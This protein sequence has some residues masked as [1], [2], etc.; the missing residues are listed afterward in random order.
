MTGKWSFAALF[1]YPVWN[2]EIDKTFYNCV[3]IQV[4]DIREDGIIIC[5]FIA[6]IA[7]AIFSKRI[8]VILRDG[9]AM[10]GVLNW[11]VLA[12]LPALEGVG[13][14]VRKLGR[15]VHSLLRLALFA[16]E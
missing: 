10:L 1:S 14:Q 3:A 9:N 11:R 8:E 13:P 4:S 5:T 6:S 2:S 12:V 15:D 16:S 7:I